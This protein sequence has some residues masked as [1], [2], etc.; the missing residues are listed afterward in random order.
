KRGPRGDGCPI[1][2]GADLHRRRVIG[3]RAVAELTAK[4]AAPAPQRAGRLDSARVLFA[5]R[6]R[7]PAAAERGRAERVVLRPDAELAIAVAVPA[8]VRACWLDRA[9]V[10]SAGKHLRCDRTERGRSVLLG[11]IAEAELAGVVRSPAPEVVGGRDGAC[12][13]GA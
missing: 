12:V 10:V 1:G 6:E 3:A 2:I 5:E 13:A 7:L 11:P 4:I 8:D 9:A